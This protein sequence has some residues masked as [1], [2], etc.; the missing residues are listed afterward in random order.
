MDKA[1][2]IAKKALRSNYRE[3]GIFAGKRHFDDYWARDSFYASFGSISLGDHEIVKKNLEL[4]LKNLRQGQVP[5]RIGKSGI[6]IAARLFGIPWKR[7]DIPRYSQDKGRNPAT[8][9]N[10]L[11][12]LSAHAYMKETK[13]M[14]FPKQHIDNLLS[15]LAWSQRQDSDSDLLIE[16][17][18]YATWA[19]SVRKK[20]KVLYSNVLYCHSI[21]C[22]SEMLSMIKD[23][24]ASSY[25]K[26]YMETRQKLDSLF[27]NGTHYTDWIDA[28]RHDQFSTDGNM[29]A[30]WLGVADK[31]R[32]I[33]I[34]DTY[35]NLGLDGDV[36]SLTNMPAY[37]NAD[38]SFLMRIYGL[39]DYHDRMSWL[40]LGAVSALAFHT[41]GRKK[42]AFRILDSM[43]RA[44]EKYGDVFEIYKEKPVNRLFY[45]SEENFSWSAGLYIF[46]H[47]VI[48]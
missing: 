11:C 5:L 39:G 6:G 40:W 44:I 28:E 45:K 7:V 20:G 26:L 32:S 27:W 4:F 9:P 8:D 29:L 18:V 35:E 38:K 10:R 33:S 17:D 30:V 34:L 16:E 3:N 37:R 12:I 41:S 13:D 21:F 2:A 23:K 31:H 25:K 42:A 48:R 15:C 43:S 47:S 36:P 1:L 19:D 46:T 22:I 14:A 24:R